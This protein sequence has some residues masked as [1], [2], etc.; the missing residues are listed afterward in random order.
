MLHFCPSPTGAGT[1]DHGSVDY[2][3]SIKDN[4]RAKD[5]P[6]IPSPEKLLAAAIVMVSY[7]ILMLRIMSVER[8][9]KRAAEKKVP[10]PFY[11]PSG[12]IPHFYINYLIPHG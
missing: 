11:L 7:L 12:T 9:L 10:D 5:L 3:L 8:T 6:I 1:P 2:G 4:W